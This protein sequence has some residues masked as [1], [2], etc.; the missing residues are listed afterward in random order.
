MAHDSPN[1]TDEIE[2]VAH[3]IQREATKTVEHASEKFEAAKAQAAG[4]AHDLGAEERKSKF[5]VSPQ[6]DELIFWRNKINSGVVL[7]AGILLYLLVNVFDYTILSLASWAAFVLLVS[8]LLFVTFSNLNTR[9]RNAP[10]LDANRA[11]WP[12]AYFRLHPKRITANLEDVINQIN[13]GITKLQDVFYSRDV[14]T[15][16]K[17]AGVAAVAGYLTSYFN[18]ITILFLVFFFAFTGPIT[19]QTYQKEID[20]AWAKFLV[21]TKETTKVVLEKFPRTPKKEAAAARKA[22]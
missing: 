15:T 2:N 11:N 21:K 17:A 9:F 18:L 7:S 10:P 5:L 1:I 22:E 20:A 4:F 16:I 12:G 8:S 14:V 3:N 6:V 19:Y 13:G